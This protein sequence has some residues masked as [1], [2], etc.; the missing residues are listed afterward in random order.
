MSPFI[1]IKLELKYMP[2]VPKTPGLQC[3]LRSLII[4]GTMPGGYPRI[5]GGLKFGALNPLAQ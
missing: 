4:K 3:D 5:D 2:C 1:P